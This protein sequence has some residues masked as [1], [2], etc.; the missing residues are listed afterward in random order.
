MQVGAQELYRLQRGALSPSQAGARNLLEGTRQ[1]PPPAPGSRREFES[2]FPGLAAGAAPG[3]DRPSTAPAPI[4]PA[5]SLSAAD[6][7]REVAVDPE[8]QKLYQAAQEFQTLFVKQMLSAMRKNLD[9]QSDPLYGGMRQDIFE[10]MLYDQY[11]KLLSERSG[12]DLADQIYRQVSAQ[13]GPVRA[14]AAE[15]DRNLPGVST[16]QRFRAGDWQP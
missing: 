15:Y 8:R 14:G 13:L 4:L 2:L 7:Q 1:D 3:R 6:I 10:D 5:N 9:R 16:S 11:A 12:F